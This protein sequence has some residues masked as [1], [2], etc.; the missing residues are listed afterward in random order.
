MNSLLILHFWKPQIIKDLYQA[1][2]VVARCWTDVVPPG[3]EVLVGHL[4]VQYNH[5]PDTLDNISTPAPS[6]VCSLLCILSSNE[7]DTYKDCDVKSN[8]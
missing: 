6:P 7:Y 2:S 1:R 8:L 5:D 4:S 3:R